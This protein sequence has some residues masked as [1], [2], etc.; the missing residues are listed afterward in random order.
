[1]VLITAQT[2]HPWAS[3]KGVVFSLRDMD[4]SYVEDRGVAGSAE[5]REGLK[6][7]RNLDEIRK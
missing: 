6:V 7:S 2:H 4:I 1:M 5:Y 3:L